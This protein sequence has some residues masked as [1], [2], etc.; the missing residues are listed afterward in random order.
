V[1]ECLGDIDEVNA[2]EPVPEAVRYLA[3]G[4]PSA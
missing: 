1:V 4:D 3:A 2:D